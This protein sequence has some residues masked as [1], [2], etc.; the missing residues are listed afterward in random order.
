MNRLMDRLH[1]FDQAKKIAV[2]DHGKIGL[3]E[4]FSQHTALIVL[5]SCKF[6]AQRNCRTQILDPAVVGSL[7]RQYQAVNLRSLFCGLAVGLYF[8]HAADSHQ[9]GDNNTQKYKSDPYH[10]LLF[11]ALPH[12]LFSLLKWNLKEHQCTEAQLPPYISV[13][14]HTSFCLSDP[15]IFRHH[16]TRRKRSRSQRKNILNH[17]EAQQQSCRN[18][19]PV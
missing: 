4:P 7:C 12:V 17:T 3:I 10:N 11:Y 1:L 5:A 13:L 2:R 9:S 14:S 16:R 6:R 19:L 18:L 8:I 15:N